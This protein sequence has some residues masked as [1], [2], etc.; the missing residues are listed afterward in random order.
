[1]PRSVF[2]VAPLPPIERVRCAALRSTGIGDLRF[3]PNTSRDRG[4]N[5]AVFHAGSV[6][7]LFQTTMLNTQTH[8]TGTMSQSDINFGRAETP[9]TCAN[10][11]QAWLKTCFVSS[12]HSSNVVA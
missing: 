6:Q 3:E 5:T 12:H 9:Y 2:L 4:S 11:S 1:M 7:M 10:N 8:T